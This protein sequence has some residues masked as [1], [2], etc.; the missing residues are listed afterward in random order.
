[1]FNG[2]PHAVKGFPTLEHLLSFYHAFEQRRVT[3]LQPQRHAELVR[4]AVSAILGYAWGRACGRFSLRQD[5]RHIIH[6]PFML[7]RLLVAAFA[8]SFAPR[9]FRTT[10]GMSVN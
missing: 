3:T 9:L 2:L 1:M 5:F 8:S 10:P 7:I 4:A 6:H